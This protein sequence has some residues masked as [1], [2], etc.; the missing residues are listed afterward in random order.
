M[1]EETKT[2]L[3]RTIVALTLIGFGAYGYNLGGKTNQ[4]LSGICFITG[5]L[6]MLITY[7]GKW[8]HWWC[9]GDE[10]FP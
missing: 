6:I 8:L 10:H 2:Y 5:F 3:L 9:G 4:I 1:Q 7:G